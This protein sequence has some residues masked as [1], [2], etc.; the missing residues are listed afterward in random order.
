MPAPICFRV[1]V[2]KGGGGVRLKNQLSEGIC[3][4]VQTIWNQL[5]VFVVSFSFISVVL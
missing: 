5:K 2:G 3:S 1:K 4:L